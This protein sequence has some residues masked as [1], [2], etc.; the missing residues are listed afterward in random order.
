MALYGYESSMPDASGHL[1]HLSTV[2]APFRDSFGN[3][4][5][6]VG[7]SIDIT[8]IKH[9][10]NSN[11]E[12]LAQNRLLTRNIF[13]A[14]EEERRY[15]ARELHD[16]LGQWFTAIQTEAQII[17]NIE[18]E[19]FVIRESALA[20]S[21]CA[22]AAHEVIRGMVRQ[23]RPSLLD[24]LGLADSLRELRRQWCGS[25]AEV[26]CDLNFDAALE[27]L[28]EELNITIYRLVQ[29]SLNN[30]ARHAYA[31]RVTVSLQREPDK[32]GDTEYIVLKVED[33]GAGFDAKQTGDGSGL[34]GMRERVIAA[35]GLFY[36]E[37]VTGA[38]TKIEARLPLA[39]REKK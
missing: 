26:I 4:I 16:E 7:A 30:V 13:V 22:S 29:E 3:I 23:L 38:G 21:K 20:I 28:G 19:D 39:N 33:N 24:E 11:S 34:L 31:S 18:K 25:H 37:S 35:G 10:L 15:L 12:L 6:L 9:I 5:G 27:G 17:C 14:Q 36:I 8:T 32:S 1:I 2:L